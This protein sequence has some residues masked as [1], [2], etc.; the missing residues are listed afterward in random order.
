MGNPFSVIADKKKNRLLI[1]LNDIDIEHIDKIIEDIWDKALKL[2]VGWGCIVNYAKVD[3]PLTL[4]LR[5]KIGTAMSFLKQL[6]MGQI[7]R[8]FR[9]DQSSFQ[10]ELKKLGMEIGGYEG[11][12]ART[13]QD[14]NTVLDLI[15]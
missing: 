1:D 12:E 14:A 13:V 10:D 7:V 2:K 4:E 5:E 15:R 9:E 8:V 3:I 11:I 6:G